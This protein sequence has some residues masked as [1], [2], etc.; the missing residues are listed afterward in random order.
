MPTFRNTFPSSYA[1]SYEN[2]TYPPM[3]ME[4]TES[5][6]TSAYKIQTPGNYPEESIQDINLF[7]RAQSSPFRN[8]YYLITLLFLSKQTRHGRKIVSIYFFLFICDRAKCL[9]CE[10]CVGWRYVRV[11]A[12]C[13]SCSIWKGDQQLW[14]TLDD[15][16]ML[17]LMKGP[18]TPDSRTP[19]ISLVS[20][21][22]TV[23]PQ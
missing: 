4:Q 7:H 23:C 13:S 5:S 19:H 21:L 16:W 8:T 11:A 2:H 20:A 3:K 1:G 9:S 10:Q 12:L 22:F 17:L 6:E 15:Q 18:L 14:M